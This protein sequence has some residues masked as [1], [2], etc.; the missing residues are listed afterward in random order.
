MTVLLS[1]PAEGGTST[2]N[3]VADSA[4]RADYPATNFGRST[5]LRVDGSPVAYSYLRFT[6]QGLTSA[7]S[8]ATLRVYSGDASGTV[9]EVRK[10]ADNTWG[11]TTITY[12]NAPTFSSTVYGSTARFVAS[13][14][15]LIDVTPLVAGN[16]TYSVALRTGGADGAI[17]S[18][19]ESTRPPQLIVETSTSSADTAAPTR[20]SGVKLAAVDFNWV[21][22]SW[23]ASADNVGVTGYTVYRNSAVVGTVSGTTLRFPDTTAA[24]ATSYTYQVDAFDSAGNRSSRSAK[25]S[26][27]TP[28]LPSYPVIAAAGDIACDPASSAFNGG[29]GT[30]TQCRQ[31]YTSNSLVN[32]RFRA[33][34]PLGDTQYENGAYDKY[35]QSYHPTWGRVKTVTR[36]ATG[37]HEYKTSGAAG[38]FRYFGSAAG[39]P[40][41][42]YYSYDLGNW[43]II[44]L[45]SSIAHDAASAQV[46]WLQ[47][48]LAASSKPC[49]LA[50]LHHPRWSSGPHGNDTSVGPF[51][52]AL[53]AAKAEVV[54]GGH[55]HTYERFAPQSPSGAADSSNGIR[56]FVVGTGGKTLYNFPS[57]KP[58][59]QARNNTTYGVLMLKLQ[60]SSYS[61]RFV[62][63][64]GGTFTDSGT[65][66][67]H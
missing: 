61:W 14:W 8:K 7:V 34:L 45:N 52:N 3:P 24:P 16:G 40:S 18:S 11:E 53:Y 66:A 43:H 32:A 15:N 10:V 60:S 35:L 13:A 42:G 26:I 62:P 57:I 9:V 59:S 33:V 12:N 58:N 46:K 23:N 25:V 6:V 28:G 1:I 19:R 36:P 31:K 51:W 63:E 55:D 2:F 49:T 65:T 41:K 5:Q 39:D 54:L 56:E 20:P 44:A 37:N 50:Y 29:N 48:D 17:P 27:K 38:Y 30:A 22:V 64:A 67:C 21:N 47:N 4:V